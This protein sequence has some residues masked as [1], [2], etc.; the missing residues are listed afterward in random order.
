[1]LKKCSTCY[2]EKDI[3]A[4]VKNKSCKN[5]RAGTCR[6]C[7]NAYSTKWKRDNSE[8]LAPIRREQY[9]NRYGHI[10]RQN[11]AKRKALY[12]LRSRAS[13]LRKGM[14]ERSRLLNIPFDK[15]ILTIPYLMDW[16]IQSPKCECCSQQLDIDFKNDNK[17]RGNSPSMDRFIPLVGYVIGN[18]ALLCWRCNNLKRDASSSELRRIADWMDSW[19]NEVSEVI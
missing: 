10:A 5:G 2:A 18:V 4:F 14:V 1:M 9:N 16:L 11:E 7:Q 15:E 17:F 19:G 6:E 13:V 12:P 3:S 8:R